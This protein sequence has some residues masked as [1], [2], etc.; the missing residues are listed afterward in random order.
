MTKRIANILLA[1]SAALLMTLP[2]YAQSY[3]MEVKIPFGFQ[4]NGRTLDSGKYEVRETS[5]ISSLRNAKTGRLIFLSSHGGA[6]EGKKP[7]CLIF[8]RYGE[9]YFLTEVWS[10]D[11]KGM[12]LPTS[13]AEKELI[14][15]GVHEEAVTV[16]LNSRSKAD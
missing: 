15:S 10:P 14:S 3:L 12:T 4:A 2:I 16:V 8:H 5:N 11:A 1:S 7:S 13:A 9:R 6:N